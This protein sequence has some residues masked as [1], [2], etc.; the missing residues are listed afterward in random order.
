VQETASATPA[1]TIRRAFSGRN[2]ERLG[3]AAGIRSS[4]A[5]RA[6]TT[7]VPVLMAAMARRA[8]ASGGGKH[9]L[10]IAEKNT[11]L[12]DAEVALA[13][14]PRLEMTG[15]S[16]LNDLLA[17]GLGRTV[18]QLGSA[19]G[20]PG[21]NVQRLL[22][23]VAPM[24]LGLFGRNAAEWRL[25]ADG[26][27]SFLSGVSGDLKAMLPAGMASLTSLLDTTPPTEAPAAV[28]PTPAPSRP[29]VGR[30]PPPTAPS[31]APTVRLD[32]APAVTNPPAQVQ[33]SRPVEPEPRRAFPWWIVLIIIL[34]VALA[35]WYFFLRGTPTPTSL[36]QVRGV[37]EQAITPSLTQSHRGGA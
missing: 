23:I 35:V 26:F 3:T 17:G 29:A 34:L 2:A 31:P 36:E 22:A 19:V 1:E 14:T 7:V 27:P 11:A 25:N 28:S 6:T 37:V 24:L 30:T 12:A 18:G 9:L 10:G 13:D 4:D 20:A 16:L 32:T 21:A 5:G 8:Q 15:Q 33:A